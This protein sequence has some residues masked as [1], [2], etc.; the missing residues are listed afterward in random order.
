MGPLG[1]SG[2]SRPV[3]RATQ[4]CGVWGKR[5]HGTRRPTL[6]KPRDALHDAF[7]VA[8]QKQRAAGHANDAGVRW[9]PRRVEQVVVLEV[10]AKVVVVVVVPPRQPGP[11]GAAPGSR[12]RMPC[13]CV[14]R[15]LDG[16]QKGLV[17]AVV[18]PVFVLEVDAVVEGGLEVFE[19]ERAEVHSGAGSAADG[20]GGGGRG[21]VGAGGDVVGDKVHGGGGGVAV[22]AQGVGGGGGR[23]D[24]VGIVV[25]VRG[26][27]AA[28]GGDAVVVAKLWGVEVVVEHGVGRSTH[29]SKRG[30]SRRVSASPPRSSSSDKCCR[31]SV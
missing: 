13:R 9:R 5:R 12:L 15:G 17:V 8:H 11:R 25:V 18:R 3:E 14:D 19:V 26:E 16:C 20:V 6:V 4:S 2:L 24:G 21:G 10:Q 29:T 22:G 31:Y 30:S 23:G 7:A 28:V 1:S 27:E